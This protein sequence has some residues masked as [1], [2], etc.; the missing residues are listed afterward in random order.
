M[1]A[2]T[3]REWRDYEREKRLAP[4]G[5]CGCGVPLENEEQIRCPEC[6]GYRQDAA[7]YLATHQTGEEVAE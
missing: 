6:D 1:S 5:R 4:Y 3:D 2:A 7:K